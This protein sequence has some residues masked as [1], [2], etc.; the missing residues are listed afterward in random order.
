MKSLEESH[1]HHYITAGYWNFGFAIYSKFPI[2][3]KTREYFPEPHA[4]YTAITIEVKETPLRIFNIHPSAPGTSHGFYFR[5][6]YMDKLTEELQNSKTATI[7]A[8]DF[9]STIFSSYFRKFQRDTGLK[10][11]S[12][13]RGYHPTYSERHPIFGITIDH[14]L[15]SPKLECVGH[16]T[17]PNSSSDHSPVVADFILD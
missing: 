2:T 12:K 16:E 17:G 6:E 7:I 4:A 14:I 8:G 3:D 9:N 11:A 13:G 5:N 15:H 10:N 1:P